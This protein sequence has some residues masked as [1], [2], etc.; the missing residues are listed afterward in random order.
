MASEAPPHG[1][2][3]PLHSLRVRITAAFLAALFGM[4]GVVAFLV[5]QYRNVSAAQS[6]LT[7]GYIPLV[8]VVDELQRDQQ[9]V[10]TDVQRLLS[11]LPRPGTGASSAT[12]IYTED[13]DEALAIARRRAERAKALAADAEERAS[14]H[15]IGAQLDRVESLH[16]QYRQR[17]ATVVRLAE[18][19][20][21][22]QA[23]AEV[24]EMVDAGS[25]LAA[26]I[27]QLAR[28]LSSRI[29]AV[30]EAAEHRRVRA[31]AVT[32]GVA[33]AVSAATLGLLAAVLYA[34]APIARLTTEV[35]RVAR[36]EGEPIAVAGTDE[37]AALAQ[38]FNRM[39]VAIQTR[40]RSLS[41]RAIE[42][43]RVSRHLTSVLDALS[44]G[45]VVVEDG[46]VTLANPAAERDLGARR[47]ADPPDDLPTAPGFVELH[48][49]ARRFE[50]ATTAFGAAGRVH[51][52][53]DVT[54]RAQDRERLARAERLA[55]VGQL[56]A[57]VTHEVRNP[58][59]ALSLN[60]ELLADELALLD[61]AHASEAWPILD[62]ISGGIDRLTRLTA[63]YLQ[64]ARRPPA[65]LA[66]E[67]VGAA[68]DEVARLLQP[69]LARRGVQWQAEVPALPPLWID[70]TQLRQALLNVARNALEA[71]ATVLTLTVTQ[72]PDAI[73]LTLRDDG[74]GMTDAQIAHAT[75]PFWSTKAQGTGL[76]LAVTR[77]ILEEHGGELHIDHNVGR[78]CA[79]ALRFP[80]RAA[81]ELPPTAIAAADRGDG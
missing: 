14:L 67:S 62:T 8:R 13:L 31:N 46:K 24:R 76:G 44:E 42:L 64:L 52:V 57:Q 12:A 73:T 51:V 21:R 61:P 49:D 23:E 75:D 33:A 58:L 1:R 39:V 27:D 16:D 36:G 66:A 6:L 63:Q 68:V 79:V 81:D 3:R 60:A 74:H 28:Q 22:A 15:R 80:W 34:L 72:S 2:R 47:G 50:A 7:E 19:D 20:Q 17:A 25:R 69:E 45:L 29:G 70:G 4:F 77:Q 40:D 53:A 55:L 10:D 18:A 32:L 38:E 26:E 9:R 35:Q 56:L 65:E 78:G 48:R 30:G 5:A 71:D 37:V 54:A 59:N 41:E 11:D 43:D